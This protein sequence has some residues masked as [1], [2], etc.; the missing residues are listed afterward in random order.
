[1]P[2]GGP[3][4]AGPPHSWACRLLRMAAMPA[5][6]VQDRIAAWR[7]LGVPLALP[8]VLAWAALHRR[9]VLRAGR[10]LTAEECQLACAVGVARPE[11]VGVLQRPRGPWPL[12]WFGRRVDAVT[13]GHGVHAFGA[14]L[15]PGLLAHELR[16]VQQVEA[17]GS[18]ARFLFDYLQQVARHG[19]WRAPL[20]VD[21]REAA[22]AYSE[23]AGRPS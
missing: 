21:A 17:A 16:H 14:A 1:M 10:P 13:V 8:V 6:D 20:E 9:R 22:R 23:V 11:Q 7:V 3:G 12:R 18:L 5:H 4:P 2:R 15:T 19:Y